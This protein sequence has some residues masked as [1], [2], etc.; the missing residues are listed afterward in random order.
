MQTHRCE[1]IILSTMNFRDYDQIVTVFSK[2]FGLLKFIAKKANAAKR[3]LK[4]APFLRGEFIFVQ[5]QSELYS[6]RALSIISQHL[7]LRQNLTCLSAACACS[8]ALMETQLLHKP[9]EALYTLFIAYLEQLPLCPDPRLLESSFLLKL[10]RHEG[11]L[12]TFP[13]NCPTETEILNTLAFSRSFLQINQ[14]S[15]SDHLHTT[16]RKHYAYTIQQN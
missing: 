9:A 6:L 15:V 16:I 10:L 2:D 7:D 1:G 13:S 8:K 14:T 3:G 4:C 12:D 11:V 5:S